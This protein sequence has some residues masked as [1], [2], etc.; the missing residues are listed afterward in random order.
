MG[1]I[2]S[3]QPVVPTTVACMVPQ[4][5]PKPNGADYNHYYLLA[6]GTGGLRKEC[7]HVPS[8]IS[9]FSPI[10]LLTNVKTKG[11]VTTYTFAW[12]PPRDEALARLLAG[13]W[14][15][16]TAKH[17][18]KRQ[19]DT[20]GGI[21]T[22]S[23]GRWVVPL[24]HVIAG[25]YPELIDTSEVEGDVIALRWREVRKAI[26]KALTRERW[27]AWRARIEPELASIPDEKRRI[28]ARIIRTWDNTVSKIMQ[29]CHDEMRDQI[30]A[31]STK[32][33]VDAHSKQQTQT[34]TQTQPQTG[35]GT[36]DRKTNKAS[37]T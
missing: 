7:V 25:W 20:N 16:T 37:N 11:E 14:K 29:H 18:V 5:A 23:G 32:C 27:Q 22:T 19:D 15:Y 8:T 4:L 3:K 6:V 24:R 35:Y 34:Q 13:I 17:E 31:L 33:R 12:P 28:I 21:L 30:C 9:S 10:G 36:H 26:E 1:A 2:G